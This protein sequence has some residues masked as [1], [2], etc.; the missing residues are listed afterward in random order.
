VRPEDV[1]QAREGVAELVED[2]DELADAVRTREDLRR[3]S[4][5]GGEA[6]AADAA[7][8]NAWK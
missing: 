1:E 6:D 5:S 2:V 7:D 8:E 3:N 4:G